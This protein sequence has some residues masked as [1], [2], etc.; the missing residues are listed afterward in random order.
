MNDQQDGFAL[1]AS[2][3]SAL[4]K[5][6]RRWRLGSLLLFVL[7][8]A[9]VVLAGPV[10]FAGH[11]EEKPGAQAVVAHQFIL[12][13][14][15]GQVRGRMTVADGN[16]VLQFYDKEGQLWWF[17]PPKMGVLPVVKPR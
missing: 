3:L 6:N 9:A 16:P 17:A 8:V 4:E 13:D 12:T 2:R 5:S 7:L 11:S 14:A 10:S 1:L 15:H